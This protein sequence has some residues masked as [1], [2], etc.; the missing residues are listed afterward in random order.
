VDISFE[1]CMLS[2]RRADHSSRGVMPTVIVKPRYLEGP[3]PLGAVAR[4]G[5]YAV[6][7]KISSNC[8]R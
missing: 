3:S 7:C 6:K 2:L 8:D 4:S 5:K 1:C